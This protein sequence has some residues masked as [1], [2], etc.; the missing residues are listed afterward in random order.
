MVHLTELMSQDLDMLEYEETNFKYIDE[1]AAKNRMTNDY[2]A[3][4]TQGVVSHEII[5][6][7]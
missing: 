5:F 3:Y 1:K 6:E 7:F 2:V 4:L